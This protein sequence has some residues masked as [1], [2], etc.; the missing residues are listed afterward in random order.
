MYLESMTY[1]ADIPFVLDLHMFDA[2]PNTNVT[3]Q[4]TLSAEMKTF[5][6]KNLIENASPLLVHDR[7]AQK[8][9]IPRNGGKKIEF[10]KYVQLGKSHSAD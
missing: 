5:Y 1:A 3:T 7:W 4:S 6:D 9:D 10:R 2:N 8:R